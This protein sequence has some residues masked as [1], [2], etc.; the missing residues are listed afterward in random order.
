MQMKLELGYIDITD[1]QF[2]AESKVENGVI[3]VN[4][5]E[6]RALLLED[7]NLKSVDFEI[8]RPGESV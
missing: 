2:A 5:D 6:L 3:Y 8:A 1:I 7:E 4:K